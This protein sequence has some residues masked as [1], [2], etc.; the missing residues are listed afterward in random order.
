[1]PDSDTLKDFVEK[2]NIFL[3]SMANL[4]T[5]DRDKLV[6]E[7]FG[8]GPV[9]GRDTDRFSVPLE[10]IDRDEINQARSEITAAIAKEKFIKGALVMLRIISLLG[11]M[12]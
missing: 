6:R 7:N 5:E 9:T 8:Y 10:M 4:S 12:P 2:G 1:M 11:G 3:E